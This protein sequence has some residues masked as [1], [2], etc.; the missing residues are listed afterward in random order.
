MKFIFTLSLL[1]LLTAANSQLL[2]WSPN[3]ITAKTVNAVITADATKG[4]QGL[5]NHTVNDV[6]VHIGVITTVSSSPGD[7]QHVQ[8]TWITTDP[9][10]KATPIG[11]NKW[12]YTITDSLYKYFGIPANSTEKILK[13]AILFHAGDAKLANA[14]NSDMFIPVYDSG[15]QTSITQPYRQPLFTPAPEPLTYNAG[16]AVPITAK[17][18]AISNL[19]LYYNGSVV[20]TATD[21]TISASH[22]AVSGDNQLIVQATSEAVTKYDTFSFFINTPVIT[23]DLPAGVRDGINYGSDGTSVTLVLF[24]PNKTRAAV[25][26]DFNNWTQTNN[27]QMFRTPDGNRYWITLT[28]LTPGQE[29]AYQYLVDGTLK[30]ADMF[31]EKILDPANDQYI[32][33]QTYP[34][35]KPYPVGQTG[36]VSVLQ[37]S[38]P[39]YTWQMPNFTKPDKRNLLIYELLVRDFVAAHN[40]QTVKD[41]IAYLKHLGVNA[42][43]VMPFNEFEGNISWGYN[44]DF[45][46]APDKYYGTETA[47][48][49]FIDEC[50]KQGIAVI[51]DLV[52]NHAFGSSP[53]VQLYWDPVNNRPATNNPWHNPVAPHPYSVGYDFNHESPATQELVE[54]VVEH[55]LTNYK[56]DGF[57]WDLAKGFT[58]KY[59]GDSDSLFSAYDTSRVITW[60]RIYDTMQNI[61][62]DSYCILEHFAA[63]SEEIDLSNYGMMLWGNMNYNYNQATMGYLDKNGSDLT[64][65]I[66]SAHGWTNPNLVTYMESHDEERLMFKNEQYGDSTATYNVKNIPTG[67]QRN[68]MAASFWAMQPAPKMLWQFG[69]LGYDY[70]IN[71][72]EDGSIN[73]DCRT[74]PKPIRKDYFSDPNRL[75]LHNVYANLFALRNYAPYLPV[76]TAPTSISYSLGGGF[77]WEEINS[78]PLDIAVIGNF[79]VVPQ[80]GSITFPHTGVWYDYLKD[81]AFSLTIQSQNYTLQ[82]GEYHIF[83]DHDPGLVLPVQLLSIN[84]SRSTNAINLAWATTN[85]VNLQQFVVE[86]SLNG[87]N[88][89][90]IGTVAARN[91]NSN[92]YTLEDKDATVLN[93]AGDVYYRLKMVDKDG[94]TTYSIVIKVLSLN[95]KNVIIYPNPAKTGIVYVQ[96]NTATTGKAWISIIDAVG[97]I[98]SVQSTQLSSGTTKIPVGISSLASGIYTIKV[99]G[100]GKEMVT[101]K[102]V[103]Q[104]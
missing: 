39:A 97:K 80:T 36:I 92:S 28:G 76:F 56:I 58:Q 21:S 38:K 53:T 42:I 68:A 54:R 67:L 91:T 5:L 88:F 49:Q 77:K 84:S 19:T 4:N 20:A 1:L 29:Y 25:I 23:K 13:I 22:A 9:R 6:Y 98:Y 63:N 103:V 83:I 79:D 50:H 57:R 55:W 100:L 81:S 43:E 46:F 60:K 61:V 41:S 69:E 45:F 15:L 47:L 10:F 7:W 16:D 94:R 24:A 18:S 33:A 102:L 95:N 44:P 3:F 96:L 74:S 40:W 48:K 101:Q 85:E 31:A 37:T 71:T 59:S 66:Y 82:P 34:D 87:R 89:T 86:R 64:Q 62:P 32:D 75:A 93:A 35:L 52:M 30:V 99:D 70:S 65:G 27:Y 73:N 90:A 2:T 78:T 72:C 12:T 104:H 8:T 14:D 26:G 51:M 17:S 11:N